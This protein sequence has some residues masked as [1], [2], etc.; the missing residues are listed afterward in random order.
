MLNDYS[1]IIDPAT[2]LLILDSKHPGIHDQA[3]QKRRTDF[4]HLAQTHRLHEQALPH[5]DYTEAEQN[6]WRHINER[7]Y[8]S[9]LDKACRIYLQGKQDLGLSKD[10]LPQLHLL[11]KQLLAQHQM[12]LVPAEGLIEPREFFGYLMHRKM[13]C[14]IF[15]R[16]HSD[17]EYT[18]E[19]DIVH[20]V[21]GHLPPLMN[22]EYADLMQLIGLGVAGA[23]DAELTAW[24][25]IYW[26]A[27][28]FGLIV[29]NDELKVFGAGLLSSFGEMDFCYS[30]QVTHKPFVIE[31]VMQTDF[32]TTQMQKTLFYIPSFEFLKSE[33]KKYLK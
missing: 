20:D 31:E 11:N 25:R 6:I 17:P 13:P 30:D 29:E 26:F 33:I 14:T 9:H 27:I 15:L 2:G 4:F 5:I 8:Q 12:G 19:P 7:L 28:E 23:N 18:P 32:D 24:A 3:Y 1:D 10:T 22:Q 16:H 21:L